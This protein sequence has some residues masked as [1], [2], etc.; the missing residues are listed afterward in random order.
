M[1]RLVS[2]EKLEMALKIIA[3][4]PKELVEDIYLKNAKL[5]QLENIEE[6][7]GIDLITFV[8]LNK[9]SEIYSEEEEDFVYFTWIDIE[10]KCLVYEDDFDEMSGRYLHT[11]Y[12]FK[13][14]GKT[15]AL[16]KE[17]LKKHGKKE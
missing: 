9:T 8:K 13:D 15:W 10:N 6:E 1:E 7:L 14:Y 4:T 17:E 2:K 11:Y 3:T 16:T 5:G 12:H